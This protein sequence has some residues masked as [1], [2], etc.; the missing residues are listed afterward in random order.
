MSGKTRNRLYETNN[1]SIVSKYSAIKQGYFNDQLLE[2]FIE[3]YLDIK[4]WR[5]TPIV[6]RGYAARLLA[7]DWIVGRSIVS[8]ALNC[9]IVL[10]AG[11]DTTPF[12][13]NQCCWIEIDLPQVI[14]VKLKF[15]NDKKIFNQSSLSEND[16]GIFSS[17]SQNYHLIAC[18]LQDLSR[19]TSCLKQVIQR[20]NN[21]TKKNFA[22]VNEVCLCYLDVDTVTNILQTL[23]DTIRDCA[24]RIHYIGY[25]QV[26]STQNSQF[27][28][29]MLN[30][31]K[32][33]GH[34][35]KYFPTTDQIK[36][37][38]CTKLNFNHISVLS[39]YQIYHNALLANRLEAKGFQEEPFDEFEEM[40]LYLSH[41]AL[42]MGLFIL[43]DPF[44]D[45][46]DSSKFFNRADDVDLSSKLEA[47]N[48]DAS[49]TDLIPC[50]I[51]RFGHASCYL[52]HDASKKSFIITGGF[53]ID[54]NSGN[55]IRGRC[56]HERLNDCLIVT[57]DGIR[58]CSLIAQV[59]L[60]QLELNGI[61]LDR[62]HGQVSKISQNLLF[63]NGGRQSPLESKSVVK[64]F[65]GELGD[66]NQLKIKH[67]FDFEKARGTLCWRHGLSKI[68][69]DKIFQ[70]GGLSA[71]NPQPLI[72][73]NMS[74]SKLGYIP[75]SSGE[76]DDLELLNRHS[77]G[78]DSRDNGLLLLFG[79]L[80]TQG[81]VRDRPIESQSVAVLWDLRTNRP[82]R[83]NL[84]LEECYNANVHFLSDNQFLKIGGIS[85]KS[86]CEAPLIELMDLRGSKRLAISGEGST[87]QDEKTFLMLTN[88]T[89]IN[90]ES[91][92][93]IVTT[94]GGGNYFTF[95][96]YF[97]RSHLVYNYM[98]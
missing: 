11:F 41:Y 32:S 64:T 74:S 2:E 67:Q 66:D 29:V 89:S 19:L 82:T 22:I 8:E 21:H 68:V 23:I 52:N 93:T 37:L 84:E 97:T 79:G 4:S 44:I 16:T 78:M 94:G 48:L 65:V 62:M 43:E 39:M 6:N 86:G 50:D 12:R 98:I 58:N 71:S 31:F 20:L 3:N 57:I 17:V 60:D 27:S 47:C 59:K 72:I 51:Q 95:G 55:T 10:G 61:K 54:Q 96:T 28:N 30:H 49:Q 26:K 15:L 56:R 92:K 40:D 83:F 5:R 87:L 42:V 35:L 80:K 73:W 25:E 24:L 9:V 46:Y 90:F 81:F 69:E 91:D 1:Y 63:F 36:Q 38:F 14:E 53:G 13:Y 18:D 34:P 45:K 88:S 7:M 76:I 75:I 85:C 33:L 77:F 70:V